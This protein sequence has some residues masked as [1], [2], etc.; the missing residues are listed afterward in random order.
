MSDRAEP[1]RRA[2]V[3]ILTA[4]RLEYDAV[5]KVDAG[6]VQGS[7]WERTTGPSG[8]PLAFRS[9]DVPTG[10][11]LRVAVA[12]AA[13]MGATAATNTLLPLVE[14]L[15]PRCDAMCGACASRPEKTQLGD[16]VAASRL[17]YHDTGKRLPGQVQHDLAT[18]QLRDDWKAALAGMDV[19]AQFRDADWF[20]TRPLTTAWRER[21]ALVALHRRDPEPWHDLDQK[22]WATTVP[23]LQ[24]QKLLASRELTDEGRRI[25]KDLLFSSGPLARSVAQR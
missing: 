21:R 7:T 19:V 24:E 20:Q 17:F 6:A 1:W 4:I 5:L 14:A 22:T 2:D 13:D 16:V 25:A 18:Y 15:K 8:L 3:V 23:A 10:R 11:P 9:F 12:V